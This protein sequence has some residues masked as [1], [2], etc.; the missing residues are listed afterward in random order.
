ER[1]LQEK[2]CDSRVLFLRMAEARLNTVDFVVTPRQP[3]VVR[4]AQPY[5]R[6]NQGV[7]DGLQV[8][9]RAADDLENV[10]GGGLLLQ[11]FTQLAEQTR[12]LDGDDGVRGEVANK[13]GLLL[14]APPHLPP[15]NHN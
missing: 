6:L 13:L 2:L 10:G 11:R 1:M 9:G 4:F 7:E 5:R 14:R 15:V 8:E 3:R 12:V